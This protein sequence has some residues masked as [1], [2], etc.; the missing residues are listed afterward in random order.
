MFIMREQMN[1]IHTGEQQMLQIPVKMCSVKLLDCRNLMKMRG[2]IKVEEQQSDEYYEETT[3]K[4]QPKL[5]E[6]KE[7]HQELNEAEEK[8]HDFT[9][10]E[11]SLSCSTKNPQRRAAKKS[12]TCSQC[13]KNFACK[14]NLNIHMKI[15]TGEKPFTCHQCGKCFA[16]AVSL[17]KHVQHHCSRV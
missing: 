2:E 8:H 4:E 15:H 5:M 7:E 3:A 11:K 9:T 17:K 1:V 10:G 12:L 13:E 16:F 14:K 6:V